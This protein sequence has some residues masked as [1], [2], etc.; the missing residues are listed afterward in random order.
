MQAVISF[1]RLNVFLFGTIIYFFSVAT[2]AGDLQNG[3][4]YKISRP[5]F[6]VG[7]F[8]DS[9]NK[10]LSRQTAHAY[11]HTKR[12]ATKSYTAFQNEV[13]SGTVM[14]IVTK[15]SRPWYHFFAADTYQVSLYPDVSQGL[16]VELQLN[17]GFEGNL[18]GLNADIF[19]PEK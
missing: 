1:C 10:T 19:S 2:F 12:I 3:Q 14:T 9:M 13:S 15:T 18:D 4:S 5:I 16:E 7:N 17:R 6:I 11:L 8:D